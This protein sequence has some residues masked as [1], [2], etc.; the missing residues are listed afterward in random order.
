MYM[1]VSGRPRTER[2]GGWLTSLHCKHALAK[3]CGRQEEAGEVGRGGRG[4]RRRRQRQ[5]EKEHNE[6]EEQLASWGSRVWRRCRGGG[7]LECGG[8]GALATS[9]LARRHANPGRPSG[10]RKE[11]GSA[12]QRDPA[13]AAAYI[14]TYGR[15][16]AS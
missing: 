11:R 4:R 12:R 6:E 2:S 3:R 7:R 14:P 5:D 9:R 13:S 8:G 16:Q 10:R 15:L 1:H